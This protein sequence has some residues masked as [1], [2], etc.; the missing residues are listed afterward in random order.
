[1]HS[2]ILYFSQNAVHQLLWWWHIIERKK[3]RRRERQEFCSDLSINK[4]WQKWV[5]G[6]RQCRNIDN[7]FCERVATHKPTY[8]GITVT[9]GISIL[10]EI[11]SS[12]KSGNASCHSVQNLLSSSLL[13]KNL[14][15]KI[16]RTI[17][18]LVVLYG[19]ENLVAHIEGLT[20]A[21]RVWE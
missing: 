13:S 7:W 19:R 2:R 14:K 12:L 11:K 17:I 3:R 15:I 16:C 1:M 9:N 10:S 6:D 4:C 18:L 8:M 20:Q 5:S 21:D